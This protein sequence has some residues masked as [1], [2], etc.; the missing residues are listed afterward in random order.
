MLGWLAGLVDAQFDSSPLDEKARALILDG[1]RVPLTKLEFGVICYLHQRKDQV[2]PRDDLLRDI[3]RQ[4]FGGSNVV[5][6]VVKSLRKKL[7]SRS[8]LIETV[9][10]H[11]YRLC[12]FDSRVK[13]E[14]K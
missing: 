9:T 10:G 5:D 14:H 3:W 13:Q 2:V 12:D 1:R 7:G 4:S 8:G 11:G 6:A